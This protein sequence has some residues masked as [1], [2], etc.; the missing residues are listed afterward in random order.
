[1]PD[2]PPSA[3]PRWPYLEE[4]L[5]ALAV[6]AN[7]AVALLARHFPYQDAPNHIA[8]YVLMDR[9][10][11]GE[12]PANIAVRL[13]PGPYLAVDLVGVALV[14]LVGPQAT[15]RLL[16]A[17]A[18]ALLPCGMYL[19]L[20]AVSPARRGWALA[21][22]VMG[23]TWFVL[24]G[25]LNY[26]IGLGLAFLWLAWWWP[27][28]THASSRTRL[29]LAAGAAAIF[30]VHMA[31]ALTVLGVVWVD[32]AVAVLPTLTSWR[33]AAAAVRPPEL[34]TAVTTTTAVA[35]VMGWGS[36]MAGGEQAAGGHLVFRS[37]A[38]KIAAFGA[39]FYSLS[40]PQAAVMA[41]GFAATVLAFVYANRRARWLNPFVA[42][43]A[44]FL[45]LFL[46]FPKDVG[47]AGGTD[48]RWL[49]PAYLLPFCVPGG[50]M[51]S[52]GRAL[53][54][55]P[56]AA[57]LIHAGVIGAHTREMDRRLDDFDGV[58]GAIP[59]RAR[60][61]PLISDQASYPRVGPY[62]QYAL[63]HTVR[64]R[65]QV[66]GLWSHAGAR[67]G[68]LPISHFQHF[69][70]LKHTYHPELQWGTKTFFPLDWSRIAA[71]YDYIVQVS[72]DN[73]VR[74]YIGAHS[75]ERLRRGAVTLFEVTSPR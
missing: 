62:Q 41:A 54:A 1:M 46:I 32:W 38:S 11:S 60:V 25:M 36:A 63:W 22:A 55:V 39:P 14:R 56:F 42:S 44:A 21:G 70:V 10:W 73:R 5:L 34:W 8:R 3:R 31:A 26:S 17:L 75:R 48:V 20:R 4:V 64:K 2:E 49:M 7:L 6:A 24:G 28:R 53:L 18:L 52:R 35:A 43:S 47:G 65:G 69:T 59:P 57:C 9:F 15:A 68:E 40:L 58:L 51:S 12:A 27:R 72:D 23:F 50:G 13:V 67:E 37:L 33:R 16:S 66:P 61:L 19:L 45:V 74:E 71:E 29:V 30:A